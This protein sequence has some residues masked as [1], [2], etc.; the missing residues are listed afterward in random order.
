MAHVSALFRYPI[1]GFTPEP[2]SELVV[3]DDGRVAGDRVLAFR[4]ADATEPEDAS[5][6]DSW[7][8]SRGLALMDF[9]SIAQVDVIFDAGVVRLREGGRTLA[10]AELD[11]AGR[12]QLEAAITA[13]IERT[14]DV[15]LLQRPGVLPLRLIGDGRTSRFQDRARGYVSLHG[16][17]SVEAVD[18]AV[19]APVDDRRFRSNIVVSGTTPWEEL[20]WSGRVRIGEVAFDV[21]RP[22]GRCAAITA[23]PDTGRRDARLLRVLTTEF[24]QDEPTLGIL[25]L[26]SHGGGVVRVGDEVVI[27]T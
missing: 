4:F 15:K 3:Q 25:L 5:G 14:A 6:L 20:G 1:K 2:R 16:A 7:P 23:N 10:E 27:E 19:S 17:A 9:P 24:D 18:A 8:K 13:F 26:P 12:A 11:D 21:Q 22:I